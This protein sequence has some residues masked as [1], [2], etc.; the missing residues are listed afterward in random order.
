MQVL[1][2]LS[3]MWLSGQNTKEYSWLVTSLGRKTVYLAV[4]CVIYYRERS[5]LTV[6]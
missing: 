5:H 1:L 6:R 2:L 3:A 4:N